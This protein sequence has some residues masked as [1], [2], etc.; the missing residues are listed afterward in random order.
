MSH[1]AD[2]NFKTLFEA[3]PGCYLVLNPDFTIA[4]VSDAYLRATVTQRNEIIGRG[5]FD[6]FPDNPDDPSATGVG[7]LRASLERV[8]TNRV[9]DS[10]AVQKYD[11]RIPGQEKFEI[12]YW[13]PINSPV[14]SDEKKL[15]YI[16]HRVEDV[17]EF[18]RLKQLGSEQ[19]ARMESEVLRRA[20]ELQISNQQLRVA[21]EELGSFSYAVSHDLR[22]PLRSMIGFSTILLEDYVE[23]LDA[24]AQGHLKRISLAA[25]KMDRLIHGLLSLSGLVQRELTSQSVDL[26]ALAQG[27]IDDLR[28][29]EPQ[30]NVE[31]LVSA[32]MKTKGD[33]Q[34]LLILLTNLIG[35]AWKFTAKCSSAKIEI[36]STSSEG[37]D[38]Y[39]VRDNGAGFDMQYQNKL[40]G[41]FQRLHS[42]TEFE[43]TGIG[44][45]TVRRVV[46]RHGGEVWAEG[47][48]DQGATFYF[49]VSESEAVQ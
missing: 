33:P 13:S 2:P 32:G 30:R 34:L 20:Q 18:V 3:A 41:A 11:I 29:I 6:V 1:P 9:A 42:E 17:T 14:L 36:G 40:F 43:G 5:I 7:N 16:I 28:K 26:S 46:R 24:E 19:A 31:F 10:M 37:T 49:T 38:A 4:A 35:N 21:N 44:L 47:K 27:V 15:T 25:L 48:V 8:R 23:H 12:R 39:Y 45:A 22:A